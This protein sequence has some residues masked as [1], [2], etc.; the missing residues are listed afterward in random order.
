MVTKSRHKVRNKSESHIVAAKHICT[1][2]YLLGNLYKCDLIG[3][4]YINTGTTAVIHV[5]KFSV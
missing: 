2:L 4:K 3:F 1:W 5:P